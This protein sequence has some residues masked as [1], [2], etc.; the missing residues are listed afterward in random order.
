LL[1]R[2]FDLK[3]MRFST[4]IGDRMVMNQQLIGVLGTWMLRGRW[5]RVEN[6][7]FEIRNTK[8]KWPKSELRIRSPV[9]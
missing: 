3:I 2:I 4:R 9:R 1:I 8:S 5:G 7:K 6:S